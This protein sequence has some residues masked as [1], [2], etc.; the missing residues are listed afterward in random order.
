MYDKEEDDEVGSPLFRKLDAA[1]AQARRIPTPNSPRHFPFV[2]HT[3]IR[4]DM[5]TH[6][7]HQIGRAGGLAALLCLLLM[8]CLGLYHGEDLWIFGEYVTT[9]ITVLAVAV[10]EGLPLAVTLALVWSG[11]Q[12]Q[13]N[14]STENPRAP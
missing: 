6:P 2:Q 7:P 5:N 3:A 1:V 8:S 13:P 11:N 14:P 12:A 4:R 9:S 10:P